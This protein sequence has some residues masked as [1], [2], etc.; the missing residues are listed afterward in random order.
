MEGY[1]ALLNRNLKQGDKNYRDPAKQDLMAGLV[2]EKLKVMAKKTMD[3]TLRKDIIY[4][5]DDKLVTNQ[6]LF[7]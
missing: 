5:L 7:N 2:K 3:S 6:Y 1:K 4:R